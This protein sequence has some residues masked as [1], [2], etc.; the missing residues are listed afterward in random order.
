MEITYYG[1]NCVLL[2]TKQAKILIDPVSGEYG[3]N[4]KVKADVIALSQPTET[5]L[6]S[7][8]FIINEPGEYEIKGISIDGVPAQLHVEEDAH[9][10]EATIYALR[11]EKMNV[12][13]IGNI[14]GKMSDEQLERIDGADIVI[15]PVGGKGLTLDKEAAASLL[16]HFEPIYVI[17][18]HYD[19]GA[20]SYPMPQESVDGFLQEVSAT[21]AAREDSIKIKTIDRA[22]DTQFVV[23]NPKK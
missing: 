17:P 16:R 9:T 20:T 5:E 11:F 4:P 7:N 8:G 1:A 19:D 3:P 2:S 15:L 12:V 23:L 10:L 18:T 13:V 22:E 14:I 6:K 21:D